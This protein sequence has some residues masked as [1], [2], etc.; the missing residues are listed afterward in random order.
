[1]PVGVPS[2]AAAVAA[3]AVVTIT[4]DNDNNNNNSS[5][6]EAVIPRVTVGRS[7]SSSGPHRLRPWVVE[8]VVVAAAGAA[9]AL[10]V[11]SGRAAVATVPAPMVLWRQPI[12]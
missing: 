4:N 9:A 12:W 5:R 10:E 6:G 11:N 7:N 8:I 1:M 3:V 2:V